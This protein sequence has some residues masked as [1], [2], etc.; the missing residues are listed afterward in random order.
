MKFLVRHTGTSLTGRCRRRECPSVLGDFFSLLPTAA[1]F[2]EHWKRKQMRLRY[3]WDLTGFEE[4]EVSRLVPALP[5]PRPVSLVLSHRQLPV[6]PFGVCWSL[7]SRSFCGR[8][9]RLPAQTVHL[10]R[11]GG[12]AR[13]PLPPQ[14]RQPLPPVLC[15]RPPEPVLRLPLGLEGE[16]ERGLS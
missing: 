14:S 8:R 10:G 15:P 5:V 16:W 9:P 11:P 7:V 1:T 3:H 2:M 12:S 4:E 6:R 13:G